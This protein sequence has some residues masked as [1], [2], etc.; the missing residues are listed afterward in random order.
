[1]KTIAVVNQKGG[2]GKTTT[3]V[4]LSAVLAARSQNVLL[5]D[6]DPQSHC[7][8][9][10]GIPERQIEYTTFDL[11]LNPPQKAWSTDELSQHTWEIAPGFNVLPSS[12][13]LAAAEAP[14][15]GI[16]DTSDRDRRL[17]R[18]LKAFEE[19]VDLCIIDCPPTI[20]LLTFSALR[21]ADEVLIP[22]ETGFF[23]TCGASRQWATLEAMATTFGRPVCGRVLPNLFREEHSLD[24]DLLKSIRRQFPNAVCPTTVRDHLEIR[25]ACSMGRSIVDFAPESAARNDYEAVADWLQKT[26]PATVLPKEPEEEVAQDEPEVAIAGVQKSPR[27]AELAERLRR[28]ASETP[29]MAASVE[30]KDSTIFQVL[31][32]ADLGETIGITGDFNRWHPKGV[33]LNKLVSDTEDSVCGIDLLVEPGTIR[34]RLVVDGVH[35][36]D[37]AN[38]KSGE[39]PDGRPCSIVEI[40]SINA[41]NG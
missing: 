11:M 16:M 15:G 25:Q 5:V 9:G 32:P 4:H 29:E 28:E 18:G 12:V 10:L 8:A 22:V 7:A 35:M 36:L 37:P 20:G 19:C 38:P 30:P 13:R 26:P 40:T 6:L 3:S 41:E 27:V 31:Q 2:C 14:G 24:E 23:A 33:E 39:G 17:A 34:Y 1:M 21:A